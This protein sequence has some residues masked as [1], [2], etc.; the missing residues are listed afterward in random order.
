MKI[1]FVFNHF[2]T[3]QSLH[4]FKKFVKIYFVLKKTK[5]QKKWMFLA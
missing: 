5:K 4:L 3:I 2:Q 1:I